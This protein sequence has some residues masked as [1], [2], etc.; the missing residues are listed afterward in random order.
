ML[1]PVSAMQ[2]KRLP[3]HEAADLVNIL[4]FHCQVMSLGAGSNDD[5]IPLHA[6]L[7]RP[8]TN[9]AVLWVGEATPEEDLVRK[10]GGKEILKWGQMGRAVKTA[11]KGVGKQR[12]GILYMK[13]QNR[14]GIAPGGTRQGSEVG[15]GFVFW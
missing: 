3:K 7:V 4:R 14:E 10:E 12:W 5:L 15:A 13:S 2:E 11:N 8:G 6:S 1:T 9:E